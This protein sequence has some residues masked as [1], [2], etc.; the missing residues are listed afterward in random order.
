MCVCVGGGG[1]GICVLGVD[2]WSGI[3]SVAVNL[4]A[5]STDEGGA[6]D[7]YCGDRSVAIINENYN[8]FWIQFV[9]NGMT[10]NTWFGG[11]MID[12]GLWGSANRILWCRGIVFVSIHLPRS[13]IHTAK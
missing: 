1:G 11:L 4:Q 5:M 3:W 12:E 9:N 7:A 10:M 8:N 6:S 2:R 13:C